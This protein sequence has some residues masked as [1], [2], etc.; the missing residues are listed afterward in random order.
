MDPNGGITPSAPRLDNQAQDA[1][2]DIYAQPMGGGSIPPE[3]P[4][5]PAFNDPMQ[6]PQMPPEMPPIDS[7]QPPAPQ[8][9]SAWP[10]QPMDQD[11]MMQAQPMMETPMQ[12]GSGG[13]KRIIFVAVGALVGIGILAGVGF[14]GYNAGKNAGKQE[15]LAQFQQQAAQQE[16]PAE[17]PIEEVQLD[18]SETVKRDPK[19]ETLEGGIQEQINAS[20]GFV[21]LVNN[22]ER[23]YKVD[24]PNYQ[25]DEGK[26]LVKVNFVMGNREEKNNF[27]INSFNNFRLE[28]DGAKLTPENIAEFPGR[29][30]TAKLTPQ[31]QVSGSII[32]AVPTDA[33]ELLFVREQPY[34]ITNQNTELTTRIEINLV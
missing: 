20:D 32:F 29:F 23:G 11:P 15:A 3:M 4:A 18:L 9:P 17:E 26:E 6:T 33:E 8:A 22:I 7:M 2:T 30:D 25:L 16:A 27:D 34:R 14:A 5:A 10:Q 21:L 13:G 28:A 1:P 12:T 24:D 19:N 31:N